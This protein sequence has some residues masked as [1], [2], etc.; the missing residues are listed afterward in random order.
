MFRIDAVDREN[1]SVDMHLVEVMMG[2]SQPV[3]AVGVDFT[4][5]SAQAG[6][7]VDLNLSADV[8][9]LQVIS[10]QAGIYAQMDFREKR[11]LTDYCDAVRGS[12]AR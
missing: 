1:G 6:F 7:H 2:S 11:Q 9:G 5:P 10:F 3:P 8:Q 12:T 4:W